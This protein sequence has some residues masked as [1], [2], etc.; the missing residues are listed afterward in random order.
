MSR[1]HKIGHTSNVDENLFGKKSASG[2]DVV[3]GVPPANVAV[4]TKDELEEIK[5]HSIIKTDQQLMDDMQQTL[6]A[7][8]ERERVARERKE[9]MIQLEIKAKQKAKKSDVEIAKAARDTTIRALAEEKVVEAKDLVKLMSTLGARAAAFTIRDQQLIDK[10]NREEAEKE[11]IHRMDMIMEV[12]RVKDLMRRENEETEKRRKRVEDRKTITYQIK[13]RER[14]RLLAAEARD[15]ENRNMLA[16]ISRYE[17]EDRQAAIQRQ[18]DVEASRLEVIAA[19]EDAISRKRAAKQRERE[20]MD[21]IERYQVAKAAELARR[22]E[23]EAVIERRKKE[24]QA[25]LLAQQEKSQNKQAELDEL[26]ARRALEE[27]ERRERRKEK[28]EA[29]KRKNDIM[30]LQRDRENQADN[31]R[32]KED[33]ERR[34]QDEEDRKALM[35]TRAIEEREER[36]KRQKHD[37]NMHHRNQIMDQIGEIESKRRMDRSRKFEEGSKLREDWIAEQAKL[38]AIREKM[39]R[40]LEADGVNPKYLTEMRSIDIAKIMKR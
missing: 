1:Y 35:A 40:D 16:T 22:E 18:K 37:N 36:E 9:R 8:E 4:L 23:E 12:D 21:E 27:Q 6:R 20:E 15:Q 39:V 17:E 11:Y 25:A 34:R 5:R 14:E 2:R 24:T 29:Q 10:H 26:R 38:E 33:L 7:K 32:R 3:T 28:D 30:Q 13:E 19:N 31:R